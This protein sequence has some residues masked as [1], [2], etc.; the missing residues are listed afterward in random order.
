MTVQNASKT[1][2]IGGGGFVNFA[3]PKSNVGE[4]DDSCVQC[5]RK[6]GKNGYW[7]EI[8]NGGEIRAQDDTTY[9]KEN[10]AGYMGCWAVGSECAKQFE[11][12]VLFRREN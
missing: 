4:H 1:S 9:V 10:D 5:G 8:V 2:R 3:E 7:V 12:N 11:K 6:V